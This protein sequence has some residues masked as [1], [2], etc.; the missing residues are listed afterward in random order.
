[1][2]G[3][4]ESVKKDSFTCAGC[5]KPLTIDEVSFIEVVRPKPKV[6]GARCAKIVRNLDKDEIGMWKAW[7]ESVKEHQEGKP[8]PKWMFAK[9]ERNEE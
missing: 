9:K 5:G 6:Y 4:E 8:W 2:M 1:M 3:M 7:V